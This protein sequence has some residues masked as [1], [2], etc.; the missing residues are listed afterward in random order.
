MNKL[1][2]LTLLFASSLLLSACDTT[3]DVPNDQKDITPLSLTIEELAIYDGQNG[4]KAYI[5]VDGVLY[6]V[7]NNSNWNN[8]SHNGYMAGLDL[9]EEIKSLSPH[10][11]NVLEGLPIVG[12]LIADSTVEDPI[13]EDPIVETIYLTIKELEMYDGQNDQ[14]AYIAIDGII[15]DVTDES[16]WAN[17]TH[18][19]LY[20]GNDLTVEIGSS[21]H[22]ESVLEGLTAVGELVIDHSSNEPYM[23]LTTVELSLY[24]GSGDHKGYIA[25]RGVIYDVTDERKW[26]D[27]THEG[28]TAG[29]DLTS[30]FENS[31]PHSLN[32]FS[33]LTIVGEL[34]E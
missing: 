1:L 22:G 2:L 12:E 11:V 7:T 15:Y 8:G 30:A 19:G 10:G 34:I 27:G 21:P 25:V 13:I 33:D 14:L 32:I 4:E 26:S 23:Y 28:Y 3:I 9:T 29:M 18:N 16:N 24:D 20:A 6:D 31:S 17:G 5:A